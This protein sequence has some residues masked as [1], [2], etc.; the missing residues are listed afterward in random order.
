MEAFGIG[1]IGENHLPHPLRLSVGVAAL[2][3]AIG[4]KRNIVQSAVGKTVLHDLVD[5]VDAVVL[6][7]SVDIYL[8]VQC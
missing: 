1:K 5:T 6:T 4:V 7:D 3:G 8:N 2:D